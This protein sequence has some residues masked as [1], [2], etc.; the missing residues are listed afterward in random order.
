MPSALDEI[1]DILGDAAFNRVKDAFAVD[2]ATG[3]E[4]LTAEWAELPPFRHWIYEPPTPG[5]KD[6]FLVAVREL[7]PG[8]RPCR[9]PLSRHTRWIAADIEL[10]EWGPPLNNPIPPPRPSS[11]L[12]HGKLYSNIE[13]I[14]QP[15][16]ERPR[17]SYFDYGL[18]Y[19]EAELDTLAGYF[20]AWPG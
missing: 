16:E 7:L 15:P 20:A 8:W 4:Q 1:H 12:L 17:L 6:L 11:T 10:P 5:A 14:S 13:H 9:T 2:H 18:A 19:Y 3:V